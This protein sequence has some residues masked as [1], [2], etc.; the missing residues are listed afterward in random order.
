[1]H[2]AG[3]I[4]GKTKLL[5]V[6]GYPVEHSF[7]PVMYNTAFMHMGLDWVYLPFLVRPED[8]S[9]ALTGLRALSV[10]GVNLTIPHKETSLKYIDVLTPEASLIGAVNI[11]RREKDDLVGHNTDGTGFLQ[12]LAQEANFNPK[13]KKVVV[14]GAGGA[15]RA[16]ALTLARHG[17]ARMIIANRTPARSAQLALEI[18]KKTGVKAQGIGLE[19]RALITAVPGADL[20][21]Q[22][23]PVGMH[24]DNTAPP[25][26]KPEWLSPS[27]LVCDLI[28][29]PR[30]TRFL[31][32]AA[33]KGC[34]T[35]DGLGMLLYQGVQGFTWW[36]GLT[37]PVNIMRQAL[38]QWAK[39]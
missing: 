22:A 20:V 17:A 14:L 34:R 32:L 12:S 2:H 37:A 29:R 19:P 7:S 15:A 21:I 23:S 11:L 31:Q 27:T 16:V 28:Y 39:P 30:P 9:T 3:L 36:T 8:L 13:G 35:L 5:G 38:E 4:T 6:M 10:S 25:W 33:G 1:M 26:F 18:E 24:P